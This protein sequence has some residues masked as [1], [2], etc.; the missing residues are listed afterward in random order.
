MV[1]HYTE[2]LAS[3]NEATAVG[4]NFTPTITMLVENKARDVKPKIC[5]SDVN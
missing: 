4:F 2:K 3:N 5:D 1:Q